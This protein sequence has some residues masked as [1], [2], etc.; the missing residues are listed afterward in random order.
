MLDTD[1]SPSLSPL[2]QKKDHLRDSANSN[3]TLKL[4]VF[5]LQLQYP[6]GGALKI[7]LC[8]FS[9]IH[10]TSWPK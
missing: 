8:Y 2:F 1:Y 4:V 9:F 3:T 5:Q 6:T 7:I 10:A